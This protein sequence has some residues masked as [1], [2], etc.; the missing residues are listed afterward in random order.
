LSLAYDPGGTLLAAAS[1]TPGKV[2][3]LK[4]FDPIHGTVT[5]TLATTPDVMCAVSFDP[6]GSHLAAG[7]ADNAI[8]LFDV[9]T[10]R[11]TLLIEQHADWVMALAFSPDG[12]RVASSSRDKSARVFDSKTGEMLSSY[13][14]HT[15]PL[16]GVAFISDGKTLCTAGRDKKIHVWAVAEAKKT[17]E[18]GGFDSEVFR[19]VAHSNYVFSCSADKLVR[20]HSISDGKLIRTFTGHTDWVYSIAVDK[21]GKRL[22]AGS[23]DGQVRI[24]NIDDGELLIALVAAPGRLIAA[25]KD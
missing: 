15:E 12:Q 6:D 9:A 23:F 1:G 7:G 20:Q 2:G 17:T 13:L 10:T 19:I 25:K 21:E 14:G 8:R 3:E 5:K 11:Q 16:M 4:L 24:W 18:I 22:A